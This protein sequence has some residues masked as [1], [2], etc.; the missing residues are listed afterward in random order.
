VSGERRSRFLSPWTLGGLSLRQ[1][2]AHVWAELQA[3]EILDRAA[4]LSY[5]FIFALFPMLLFLIALL[6]LLP[7]GGLLDR[8]LA[9]AARVLP[10][11]A[12]SVLTGML[13]QIVRGA[14]GGLLSVGAAGALW[15]ASRGVQSIIL[16]LN[17]VYDVRHP[18]PWWRRQVVSLVLTVTFTL[19]TLTGLIL[20]GF[21]ERIGR[22]LAE[23]AGLGPVFSASWSVLHWVAVVV[24]LLTAMDLVYHFAPAV[25]QR[26]HWLT[27]GSAFALTAWLLASIGLRLYVTHFANY[28]ATYGSIGGVILLLLWLYVSSVALLVGGE[29][30]AV[31]ARAAAARGTVLAATLD[32]PPR[33][34]P[35]G[36]AR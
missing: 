10:A 20:L 30:N 5:Y 3:D 26:W 15:G 28:N 18:R 2:A 11:D 12:M 22:G 35:P 31:I 1:L 4:A 27:P 9:Y 33:S 23:R 6:G 16:A 7:I 21:G 13:D 24:L 29:I 14:G 32:D 36:S 34:S 8:L 19:F 17:V 25:R